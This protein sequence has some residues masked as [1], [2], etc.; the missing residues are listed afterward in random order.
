M[1]QDR[2]RSWRSSPRSARRARSCWPQYP[3]P[4]VQLAQT[5]PATAAAKSSAGRFHEARGEQGR[6]SYAFL[7]EIASSRVARAVM[8][9]RQLNEV[10]VDFWENHFN[11]FAGKDR[12]RYFLPE[13][14]R[15]AIRPHALGQV[16]R[17]CWARWPRARPCS[18]TWTTG[19]ASPTAVAR[20]WRR[21][22]RGAAAH[23]RSDAQRAAAQQTSAAGAGPCSASAGSTRTTRV[24]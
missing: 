20:R 4:G 5:G 16:P 3:P 11:V 22:R 10:M 21:C 6:Q 19:R 9:E 7:G 24:S 23:G 12:T 18:T 17:R 15:D 2:Q 8:T 14:E 1:T 13:Y